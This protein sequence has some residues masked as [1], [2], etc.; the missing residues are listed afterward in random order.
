ME[1]LL[2]GRRGNE[3]AT[4]VDIGGGRGDL[5]L[6]VAAAL[7]H[8]QIK[9]VDTNEK[10]IAD[11][12]ARAEASG[13]HRNM[14]FLCAD[15]SSVIPALAPDLIIGLHACGGLTDLILD[16][17]AR[18]LAS[19][20]HPAPRSHPAFL[21]VPCCFHRHPHLRCPSC[22]WT[23]QG[24]GGPLSEEE[25]S[26][27]QRLAESPSR[28]ISCRAMLVICQLRL[29]AVDRARGAHQPQGTGGANLDVNRMGLRLLEFSPDFSLR[30]LVL[31]GD[32]RP[33]CRPASIHLDRHEAAV[34]R[35][36]PSVQS[37]STLPTTERLYAPNIYPSPPAL[38]R[39]LSFP[40]TSLQGTRRVS[41]VKANGGLGNKLRV[42]LSYR[43]VVVVDG[44]GHLVV[45]WANGEDCPARFDQ[46]FEPI[47]GVT[48]VDAT[49]PN[50]DKTLRH[51][52]VTQI[53][54]AMATHP[55]IASS[56]SD[57]EAKMYLQ[58]QPIAAIS[59]AIAECVARCRDESVGGHYI[60]V[61]VRRTD[62]AKLFGISTSDDEFFSFVDKV[63]T[64]EA[65]LSSNV[66]VAVR[67]QGFEPRTCT[68]PRRCSLILP[69]NPCGQT[70]N[71]ATQEAFAGHVT[72]QRIITSRAISDAP[73]ALRHT[74]VAA[75]VVDLFVC[76]AATAFKG[77]R[78]STFTDAIWSLREAKGCAHPSD[79]LHTARQLRRHALR[80]SNLQKTLQRKA[81]QEQA[82][83]LKGAPT[84]PVQA[85]AERKAA[86]AAAK[87]AAVAAAAARA[88]T[89]AAPAAG[90]EKA[91]APT[92]KTPPV[93]T[94]PSVAPP[95][96][97]PPGEAPLGQAPRDFAAQPPPRPNPCLHAVVAYHKYQSFL[98]FLTAVGCGAVTVYDKS[99][100]S[101]AGGCDRSSAE[102]SLCHHWQESVPWP[103]GR[104]SIFPGAKQPGRY[105]AITSFPDHFEVRPVP[106]VGRESE[107]YLRFIVDRYDDLP[108]YSL[109]VQDDCHVHIPTNQR[110]TICQ[111]VWSVLEDRTPGR[112]LQVV[113]RGRKLHP[114]KRIDANDAL[115]PK[116][117][118]A[119][120]RFR[121]RLPDAYDTH[122]CAFLLVSRD[123]ILQHDKAWYQGLLQWHADCASVEKR[124]GASEAEL[125][126][127]LLEHLWTLIF[128]PP[129][130]ARGEPCSPC[131]GE[132]VASCAMG[133]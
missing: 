50:L 24:R 47:P 74:S 102:D 33:S 55:I 115:Y 62:H 59:S 110:A 122:V 123:A 43:E 91:K 85:R 131:A 13:V 5:A 9:V 32:G 6:C 18:P 58:L 20:T 57:R 90:H 49:E 4:I 118:A 106:N 97:A 112:V 93:E 3:A 130:P 14:D 120:N 28:E 100:A 127:W 11:G 76:V 126:P 95:G 2:G 75:A 39:G 84:D 56:K 64:G 108:E 65:R 114:L 109:M 66:F 17:A 77:T 68:A 41:A 7:P 111:Q 31:C 53:K 128:F 10:S 27:L 82:A 83:D 63:T 125:A 37:F 96:E 124:R 78:G 116:L 129:A 113:F 1:D 133:S 12:K 69:S 19:D 29:L 70:D 23:R 48:V 103:P 34:D 61:H 87:A 132:A 26:L 46:L 101:D 105:R 44:D 86:K 121:I 35:P 94:P 16:M 72:S 67:M 71:A 8:C 21:V 40:R 107:T 81:E 104:R 117:A 88:A 98:E 38:A 73:T 51:I 92:F 80:R 79:E 54:N 60:A 119:C 22:D 36:P 15:A 52:G 89:K 42:L 99:T 25:I 45:V 30:N